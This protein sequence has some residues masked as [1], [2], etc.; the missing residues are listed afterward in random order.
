MARVYMYCDR[1]Y[2]IRRVRGLTPMLEMCAHVFV[3]HSTCN[4]WKAIIFQVYALSKLQTDLLRCP[5]YQNMR[6]ET[7]Q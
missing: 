5:R 1:T 6:Q 3:Q 2:S 7:R 4:I